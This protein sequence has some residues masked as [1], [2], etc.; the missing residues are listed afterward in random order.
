MRIYLYCPKMGRPKAVEKLYVGSW[1][2]FISSEPLFTPGY[3]NNL[4]KNPFKGQTIINANYHRAPQAL[5]PGVFHTKKM[6]GYGINTFML[7]SRYFQF[8]PQLS[9]VS[10]GS[11]LPRN[12]TFTPGRYQE[13]CNVTVKYINCSIKLLIEGI[14]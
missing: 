3:Q 14:I 1:D 11:Y 10:G 7:L 13:V 8:K 6:S 5:R 12:R 2:N 9:F 4:C